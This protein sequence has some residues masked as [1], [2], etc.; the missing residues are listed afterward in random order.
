MCRVPAI[1]VE[2]TVIG[3]RLKKKKKSDLK[4]FSDRKNDLETLMQG[5]GWGWRGTSCRWVF[6]VLN[7]I[8]A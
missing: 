6:R 5:F 8:C 1:N 4:P 2:F 3:S 7:R